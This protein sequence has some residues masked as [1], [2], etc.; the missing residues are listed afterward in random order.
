M[1][2]SVT[3]PTPHASLPAQTASQF[4]A[5][6]P[7]LAIELLAL[8]PE[9]ESGRGPLHEKGRLTESLRSWGALEKLARE[10]LLE[11]GRQAAVPQTIQKPFVPARSLAQSIQHRTADT[12]THAFRDPKIMEALIQWTRG[13]SSKD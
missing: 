12:L 2:Q 4:I 8:S 3:L 10:S 6:L 11:R 13:K 1:D 7:E 5:Q 9:F